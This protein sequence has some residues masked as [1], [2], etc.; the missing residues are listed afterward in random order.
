M[1]LGVGHVRIGMGTT[2]HFWF[3]EKLLQFEW[4]IHGFGDGL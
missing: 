1:T 2:F 3:G 4:G